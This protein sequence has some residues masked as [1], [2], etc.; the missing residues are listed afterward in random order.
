MLLIEC[1]SCKRSFSFKI[2][3]FKEMYGIKYEYSV[4]Y[5]CDK[6][7]VSMRNCSEITAVLL[8]RLIHFFAKTLDCS[9]MCDCQT[10]ARFKPEAFMDFLLLNALPVALLT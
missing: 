5:D 4:G 3:V 10:L 8:K 1:R 7:N 6:S 9:C 2:F